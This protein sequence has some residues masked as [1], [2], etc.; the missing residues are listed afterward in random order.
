VSL[1]LPSAV[2]ANEDILR[3]R[4]KLIE[5][6][7]ALEKGKPL[8]NQDKRWLQNLANAYSSEAEIHALL[9]RVDI[10]PISLTIAQAINESGWGSS[11]FALNGNGIYGQHLSKN[12]KGKYMLSLR[13]NVKVAAFDSIYDATK[14]YIHTLNTSKAYEKLREI[15]AETRKKGKEI[16]G[17]SLA[18]GLLHYSGIGKRYI[19][20]IHIIIKRYNLESLEKVSIS[21]NMPSINIF[22]S[23]SPQTRQL[24]P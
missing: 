22:F 10:I 15:R 19:D 9:Q 6:A 2:K 7:F 24:F 16:Q 20:I 11:R 3:L 4:K 23:S 12:S 17:P 21:H 13:G 1:I 8:G 18:H 14:S 5:L